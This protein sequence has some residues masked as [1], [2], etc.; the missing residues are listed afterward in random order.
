MVRVNIN[1]W[2][3]LLVLVSHF[4]YEVQPVSVLRVWVRVRVVGQYL[5]LKY[6]ELSNIDTTN[7]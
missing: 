6:C 4:K 7:I 1:T 2:T 5:I 3:C